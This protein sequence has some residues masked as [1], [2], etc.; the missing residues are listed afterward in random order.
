MSELPFARARQRRIELR[1]PDFLP[2]SHFT[3]S[4]RVAQTY[5]H[6]VENIFPQERG[7]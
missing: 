3:R 5:S 4:L 6:T 2:S 7:L 1:N